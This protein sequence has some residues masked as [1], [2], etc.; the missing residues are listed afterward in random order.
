MKNLIRKL[1][2]FAINGCVWAVFFS[3]ENLQL[4]LSINKWS[5]ETKNI[6]EKLCEAYNL[7]V[8]ENEKVVLNT[9]H[10]LLISFFKEIEFYEPH[11]GLGYP[12]FYSITFTANVGKQV[13]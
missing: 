12:Q 4:D 3:D 5:N 13:F 1:I 7:K 6:T 2:F 8:A 10:H 11:L 9:T